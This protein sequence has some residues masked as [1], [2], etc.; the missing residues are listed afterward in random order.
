MTSLQCKNVDVEKK[1]TCE[2]FRWKDPHSS[3]SRS[4]SLPSS[5]QLAPTAGPSTTVLGNGNGKMTC[6]EPL[7]PSSRIRK[8]CGRNMCKKHCSAAGGCMAP[9][10]FVSE[11]TSHVEL[12]GVDVAA[13]TSMVLT[14]DHV[15]LAP[16]PPSTVAGPETTTSHAELP[17][18]TSETISHA[19][20]VHTPPL[21]PSTH[22]PVP[23]ASPASS[24][25]LSTSMETTCHVIPLRLTSETNRHA[26]PISVT[27]PTAGPSSGP[28]DAHPNPRYSSQIQPI[29]TTQWETE[30]K[31]REQRRREDATW[32]EGT[33]RAKHTVIVYA[34]VKVCL[35]KRTV[36]KLPLTVYQSRITYHRTLSSF[37]TALH[38]P[39]L[40][41]H[42][43]CWLTLS[44][45]LMIPF[46]PRFISIAP[47]WECGQRSSRVTSFQ[48]KKMQPCFS[49]PHL[50]QSAH[51]LTIMLRWPT[52]AQSH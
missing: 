2:F 43:P 30:E 11:S 36:D 44:S 45:P 27:M 24:A 22:V 7:C 49:S 33:K 23:S 16:G 13:D 47:L 34:W 5:S 9:S 14:T 42:L 25:P 48:L 21:V 31:L 19:E 18:L 46:H 15:E 37:S 41:L 51:S 40:R 10:H 1:I 3:A 39:I 32:I 35:F 29:F 26:V 4:P 20:P 50:C 17:F 6:Q 28:L 12:R 38:G 8:G 52:E